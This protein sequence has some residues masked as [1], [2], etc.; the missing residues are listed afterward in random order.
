[1]AS[2]QYTLQRRYGRPGDRGQASL[3]RA[4][5]LKPDLAEARSLE[6][7]M[8]FDAGRREEAAAEI[9]V[10]LRLD[11]ESNEVNTRAGSISFRLGRLEDAARHFEKVIER[12]ETDLK[13]ISMLV[14]C[15]THLGDGENT[16]RAAT[17]AL[18]GAEK[19]VAQ[20]RNN[21][22]ARAVG[23]TALAALGEKERSRD[24]MNRALLID[25]DNLQ[26]RYKFACT[27]VSWLNDADAALNI[28]E[29]V[30]EQD[31]GDLLQD[32]WN[33]PDLA[34]LHVDPR[35]Q[36]MIAAAEARLEA[37]EAAPPLAG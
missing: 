1:M 31:S 34:G 4:L 14:S 21:G 30:L 33:D 22:F 16:R 37:S 13:A 36:A 6:A 25:P 28:L 15:Y 8:L 18:E 12:T 19:V 3:D 9:A 27:L 2:G 35:F 23:V 26:M 32:I 10:A 24:W 29:P 5:A 7:R 20:D 17:L 11:P